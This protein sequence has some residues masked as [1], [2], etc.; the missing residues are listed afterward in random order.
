[1]FDSIIS[2]LNFKYYFDHYLLD[3]RFDFYDYLYFRLQ[4]KQ[5]PEERE[6]FNCKSPTSI[7][8]FSSLVYPEKTDVYKTTFW[9]TPVE[10]EIYSRHTWMPRTVHEIH[11]LRIP[12]RE[13]QQLTFNNTKGVKARITRIFNPP[14]PSIHAEEQIHFNTIAKQ[15]IRTKRKAICVLVK[16][17]FEI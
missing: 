9:I 13:L 15:F 6:F 12:T 16:I 10:S 8:H 3:E 11:K 1:M 17:L 4:F 14:T 2:G 7:L 5:S